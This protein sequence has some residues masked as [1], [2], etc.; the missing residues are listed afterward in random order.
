MGIKKKKD[1][2]LFQGVSVTAKFT[3]FPQGDAT[4]NGIITY[5]GANGIVL[6]TYDKDEY[7][8]KYSNIINIIKLDDTDKEKM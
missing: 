5:A 6:Y 8:F 3:N 1:I 4:L 7:Y 2:P